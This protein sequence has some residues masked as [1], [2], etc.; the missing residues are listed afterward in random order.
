MRSLK[1]LLV[2][3]GAGFIGSN[4][5]HFLFAR[6][7]FSGRIINVDKLT[8]AGNLENLRALDGS[9]SGKRY[10][11]EKADICD[12]EKMK[13][14]FDTYD[15]DTVVHFAAESHV[16]RS[17]HGPKAFIQTNILGTFTL[18]E[19]A[20]ARWEAREDVV[21]HHV[22][23]DEVFG[24]LGE[25]G[26]FT[27]STA[28]DPKSPYSA[29]KASSDHIARAM[30]HTYGLSVTLSNCSN[31]YGPYQFPEKL[32]PLVIL[33]LLDQKPVPVYG[34]GKNIRDWLF[35]E[36]HV[37]AIWTI[38][39]N[40]VSGRTYAIGAENEWENIV[41]V[42]ALCE[43]VA[44][45]MGKDRDALKDLIT[46]VKDRPGHDRRYAIDCSRIKKELGW[47][48][49]TDFARG[50]EQTVRWY[51]ENMEWV[52]HITSGEYRGWIERQYGV[53]G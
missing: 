43:E 6:K 38:L 16:D 11:F 2:T 46:F 19:A 29:S 47:R 17:I 22:S 7:E 10:F 49:Q 5:I 33:N 51:R 27:E 23:T 50:L 8:Y 13:T 37:R 24:S 53:K 39:C 21:F 3:G 34:D 20:R 40:G 30:H 32:I 52:Q 9:L 28:Y 44:V 25:S 12:F 48:P 45:Q 1:N 18:L 31:N 41:L 15:I 4:F 42:N 26:F 14:I 36:D 35:V